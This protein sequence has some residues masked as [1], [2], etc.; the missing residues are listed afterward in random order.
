MKTKFLTGAAAFMVAMF[1]GATANEAY[2]Q[3]G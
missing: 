2:A 3:G 1:V